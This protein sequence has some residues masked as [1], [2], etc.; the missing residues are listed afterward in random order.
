MII[1]MAE[2]GASRAY[3]WLASTVT[4]RPVAWVSTLSHSGEGN[5][6]P[7][8]FFQVITGDPPTVMISPL[9]RGDG[10]LK[11]TVLNIQATGEFVISLVPF[12]LVDAMNECSASYPHG[13]SE[14]ER[15]GVAPA[16]STRVKPPRVAASPVSLE[17]MAVQCQPYPADRPSCHVILGRV[18]AM[19]IDDAVLG[20]DG[21]VD[22]VRL[23]LVSRMGGDWY[24]RTVSDANFT[25]GR[26]Q[27]WDQ[28]R[29]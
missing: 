5:L 21:R 23:D 8:S 27:G 18:L 12:A 19:H 20:A 17:C 28:P 6:A 3:Q 11:D 16:A 26:P 29:R 25:L 7:F 10:G 1:D 24:G 2:T 15:A 9:H 4:P 14:F 22:P 13:V